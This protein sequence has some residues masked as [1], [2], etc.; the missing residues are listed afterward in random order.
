MDQSDEGD[1]TNAGTRHALKL[2]KHCNVDTTF[3]LLFPG[4]PSTSQRLKFR[5][6][7]LD[8]IRAVANMT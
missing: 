8:S 1:L 4:V 3:L 2:N 7:N 5:F 6:K